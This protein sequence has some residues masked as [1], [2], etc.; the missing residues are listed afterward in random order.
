MTAILAFADLETSGLADHHEPWE[1]AFILRIPLVEPI[2]ARF[3]V[4][5]ERMDLADGKA[6]EIGRFHERTEGVQLGLAGHVYNLENPHEKPT[7][8]DAPALAKWVANALDGAVLIGSNAQFDS[9]MLRL[10]LAR[11]GLKPTWHYRP[12]DV[13]AMAYGYLCGQRAAY[14]DAGVMFTDGPDIPSL[15]WNSTELAKALGIDRAGLHEALP[16]AEFAMAVFDAVTGGG[17]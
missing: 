16:D 10:F 13:G 14:R 9:R 8:S 11:H 2:R 17:A 5:P 4:Y 12:V 7:W 1:I 6:L 3:L 15:P